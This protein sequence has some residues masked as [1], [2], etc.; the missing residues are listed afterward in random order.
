MNCMNSV[1]EIHWIIQSAEGIERGGGGER[2]R[3]GIL[4]AKIV[5][6]CYFVRHMDAIR[7]PVFAPSVS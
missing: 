3:D 6:S 1:Q 7:M 4:D 5:H 2:E